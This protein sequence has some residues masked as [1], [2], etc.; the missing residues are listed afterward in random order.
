MLEDVLAK[1]KVIYEAI[2]KNLHIDPEGIALEGFER[3]GRHITLMGQ[4]EHYTNNIIDAI[5]QM[6]PD[7][8]NDPKKWMI[9]ME[10]YDN[11]PLSNRPQSMYF[12]QLGILLNVPFYNPGSPHSIMVQQHMLKNSD[13]SKDEIRG[14]HLRLFRGVARIAQAEQGVEQRFCIE[15]GITQE[16][17]ERAQR[18]ELDNGSEKRYVDALNGYMKYRFEEILSQN[19]SR[20]SIVVI[21]GKDH[22]PAYRN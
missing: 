9:I 15:S 18:F 12:F 22:F 17:F 16:E 4:R 3:E 5:H 6:V 20:K 7:M 19:P 14:V 11:K 21:V 1:E 2:V 10:G 13:L 8:A